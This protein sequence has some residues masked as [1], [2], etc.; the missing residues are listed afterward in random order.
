MQPKHASKATFCAEDLIT[1]FGMEVLCDLNHVKIKSPHAGFHGGDRD[2]GISATGAKISPAY[3][4]LFRVDAQIDSTG[5]HTLAAIPADM[6]VKVGDVV[7]LNSRYRDRSLPCHF[8]PW[9]I[10]RVIDHKLN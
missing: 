5:Q 6:N 4:A 3:L 10:N 2:I 7:E 9:T 8:I 1:L